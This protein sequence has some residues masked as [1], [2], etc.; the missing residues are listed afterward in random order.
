MDKLLHSAEV[1]KRDFLI[2]QERKYQKERMTEGDEFAGK[3]KFVT[4]AYKNLQAELQKA[5][6]AERQKEGKTFGIKFS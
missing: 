5:E 2:A 4:N 3:E 6:E 1:R